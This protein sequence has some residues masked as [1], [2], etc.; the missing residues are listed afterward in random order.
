MDMK[1]IQS[2]T[3]G[4]IFAEFISLLM[5]ENPN[6]VYLDADLARSLV[7]KRLQEFKDRFPKQFIDC[8]I[9]EANEVGV[10]AGLSATG[11]IPFI[12]S[13][14]TFMSRRVC[15]Q[16]FMS[17]CYAGNNI[18]MIGSDPGVLAAYNGGT[19][20]PFEDVGVLK[21]IPTIN[22]LEPSD[23]FSA[24]NI[25]TFTAKESGVFYI[26][27]NRKNAIP[28]YQSET[29][30]RPGGS[31]IVHNGTDISILASG[32]MVSEAVQAANL[33]N[34]E[35]ISARV[36]DMYSIKP[37]DSERIKE[38]V[39]ETGAIVTAENH[40]VIGGLG[41]SVIHE[42]VCMDL[43]CPVSMIGIHDM[44]G[45]VGPVD[46]L[47]Q[48]YHLTAQDICDAVRSAIAKKQ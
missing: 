28:I 1:S 21:S 42:M 15:D 33:L 18:R 31:N 24:W 20:M 38:C 29:E 25:L 10:A 12:H 30:F 41:D 46:Y 40:N 13:F 39:V 43:M 47:K 37:I 17:G 14:G 11:K 35:G 19:H 5:Q 9:Q 44:F 2:M 34:E 6:V 23:G 22:I 16:I 36:V 48:Y 8:G 32:I 26:R 7:G 27:Y 45:Q 4:E 3:M